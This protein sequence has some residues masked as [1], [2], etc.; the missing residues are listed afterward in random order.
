MDMLM[1]STTW[2]QHWWVRKEH[3]M[4]STWIC[5]KH[6][7]TS[8]KTTLSVEWADMDLMGG[9]LDKEAAGWSHSDLRTTARCPSGGQG[10][11]AFLRI[12][13]GT[14]TV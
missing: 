1:F 9:H 3:L 6:L 11:A 7:T 10:Q 8:H 14:G 4:S 2:L 13:A 5:A 12:S